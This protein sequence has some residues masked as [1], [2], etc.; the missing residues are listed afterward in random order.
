[1]LR[2]ELPAD[3][4][5]TAFRTRDAVRAGVRPGRLAASDLISPF[6]SVRAPA[7]APLDTHRRRCGA[8]LP[9]LEEHQFFSHVTAA[10]IWGIPLPGVATDG[11]LHVSAI[12]P[13]RE[14]RTPGIIGHRLSID[15]RILTSHEGLPVPA[16]AEVWAQLG[17]ALREPPRRGR[18]P[19]IRSDAAQQRRAACRVLL[20]DDLVIAADHLLASG[21]ATMAELAASLD[22]VR[23]RGASS[24]HLALAD[25]RS[26]SES[27]KETETRLI[28]MRAGLPEPELNVD[29]HDDDGRLVARLD[30]AYRRYRVAVEYDGRH[31]ADPDQFARDADR[32]AD[33]DAEGWLLVRV[34]SHHLAE[35]ARV[36]ARVRRALMSRG[37]TPRS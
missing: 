6:N 20:P 1:M 19:P 37:W 17:A 3:L 35:P 12:T 33:I 30:L 11:P 27:P 34:L 8:A 32:W 21:L 9:R 5:G 25:A 22:R 10:S 14:P 15:A 24:L 26:G 2:S 36:A 16:P 7:A 4:R 31:H 28:L 23:R 18:I 29:L 13:H